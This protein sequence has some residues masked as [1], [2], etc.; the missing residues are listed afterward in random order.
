MPV[1][2]HDRKMD[3]AD[4]LVLK[5]LEVIDYFQPR[6]WWIEN[7]STGL[8]KD[9][10]YMAGL[11]FVDLDYCQFSDWVTENQRGFGESSPVVWWKVLFVMVITAQIW[12]ASQNR[13]VANDDIAYNC[14]GGNI[15]HQR[16][17]NIA[18]HQNW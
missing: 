18:F 11:P 8:L 17:S 3:H 1:N 15:S 14:R 9:R 6:W 4:Q 16:W 10:P 7:P 13:L 12:W 5:V 2:I